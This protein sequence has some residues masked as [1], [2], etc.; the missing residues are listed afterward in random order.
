MCRFSP[1]SRHFLSASQP[2]AVN[3]KQGAAIDAAARKNNKFVMEAMWT[4]FI[5]AVVKVRALIAEGL[6]GAPNTVNA[7]FGI[8]MPS[9]EEVPRLW[10]N[11]HAGGAVLDL[12][13]YA[14]A[15]ANMVF[16]N[17]SQN[18][19]SKIVATGELDSVHKVD[20][21]ESI[22]LQ[23]G[24]GQQAFINLSFLGQSTNE[25]II[26]GS[27]GYIRIHGT[28]NCSQRISHRVNGAAEETVLE[29]LEPKTAEQREFLFTDS[30]LMHYEAS[31][32]NESI[33]TG[34]V[35]SK[36]YSFAESLNILKIMDEVRRQVGVVYACDSE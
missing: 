32:I 28:F 23:Y 35:Q 11:Q 2:A 15:M 4:R 10:E 14:I 20:I 22:S 29:F 18:Y 30:Q 25:V 19:P 17:G 13:V 27:K 21:Q 6:I 31:E 26:A 24:A 33:R 3:Y 34:A 7:T 1:H 16:G 5:P 8:R 36:I 9:A 12:G